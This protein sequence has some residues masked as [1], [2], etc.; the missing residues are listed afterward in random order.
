M[1]FTFHLRNLWLFGLSCCIGVLAA[2]SVNT[3]AAAIVG[4]N[5]PMAAPVV[6]GRTFSGVFREATPGRNTA[7]VLDLSESEF[8]S[9]TNAQAALGYHLVDVDVKAT[10]GSSTPRWSGVYASGTASG[11]QLW[12]LNRNDFA[13]KAAALKAAGWDLVD[14]ETYRQ[15]STATHWYVG[16]FRPGTGTQILAFFGSWSDVQQQSAI[17]R[18][19]PYGRHLSLIEHHEEGSQD[20]FAAVWGEA[21]AQTSEAMMGGWN[22]VA[23]GIQQKAARGLRIVDLEATHWH[24]E[25]SQMVLHERGYLGMWLRGDDDHEVVAAT[26]RGVFLRKIAEL[27]QR[28]LQPIRI[29]M[30][31]GFMPPVGLA[32]NFAREMDGRVPGYSYAVAE[33]GVVTAKGGFGFARPLWTNHPS[34]SLHMSADTRFDVASVSKSLLAAAVLRLR[35]QGAF[36]PDGIDQ[37]FLKGP[38]L[39]GATLGNATNIGY[40]ME[41]VTIRH[42]L[43]MQSS[44]P[45]R[46]CSVA[47]WYQRYV[48]TDIP[49]QAP[50]GTVMVYNNADSCVLR[51]VIERASGKPFVQ[52]LQEQVLT[53]MGIAA[54]NGISCLPTALSSEV[55]YFLFDNVAGNGVRAQSN[56]LYDRVCGAGG[57]HASADQ[58]VRFLIGLRTV[59]PQASMNDFINQ[60][61]N[62]AG[63]LSSRLG[64]YYGKNGGTEWEQGSVSGGTSAVIGLAPQDTQVVIISNATLPNGDFITGTLAKAVNDLQSMPIHGYQLK[65]VSTGKCITVPT[66][67][68]S[69]LAT[70]APCQILATA[71][72]RF[73]QSKRRWDPVGTAVQSQFRA[74]GLCLSSRFGEF[75]QCDAF[76]RDIE[77]QVSP[78]NRYGQVQLKRSSSN[79][80]VIPGL[81]GLSVDQTYCQAT[82]REFWTLLP[83]GPN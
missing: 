71:P 26:T 46:D 14:L 18:Q 59:L 1:R 43:R 62:G 48:S 77:F 25:R 42:L 30:E 64:Q 51:M 15:E 41:A 79:V 20:V 28:G 54:S 49:W 83:L 39:N 12:I 73:V 52:Y 5:S 76:F 75:Y 37:S 35:D 50:P 32:A 56:S 2:C 21:A 57:L 63:M 47:D 80:C 81:D 34:G 24:I 19:S 53:P 68:G 82:S 40:L 38:Y 65:S 29:E 70:L 45:F 10:P 33:Q 16:L 23:D 67:S 11:T 4:A 72:Q 13:S 6:S 22:Q 9:N 7:L 55:Q 61:M 69:T 60:M 17:F 36:G 27:G 8:F 3:A 66:S 74:G 58:I 44:V 78:P 31:Q